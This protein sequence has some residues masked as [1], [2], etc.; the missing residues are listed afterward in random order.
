[1]TRRDIGV[2]RLAEERDQHVGLTFPCALRIA[3]TL[4]LNARA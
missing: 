4:R 1:M 3:P 2:I